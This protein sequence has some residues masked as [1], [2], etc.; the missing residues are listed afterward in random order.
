[1][2]DLTNRKIIYLKGLMFLITG[3]ISSVIIL[4][5]YPKIKLALLLGITVWA[6]SRS[7]YF[8][9]YVIEHYIDNNYKFSGLW[10]FILYI[11]R[12]NKA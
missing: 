3:I 5:D 2:Q 9:F 7:Y 11:C 12:K 4:I 8:A 1:M 6:F 10:S